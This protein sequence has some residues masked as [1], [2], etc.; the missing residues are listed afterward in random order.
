MA[1]EEQKRQLA[2]KQEKEQKAHLEEVARQQELKRQ[3]AEK[4]EKERQ[5]HLEEVARQQEAQ[6][7]RSS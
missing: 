2:E 1:T 7:R 6:R 5:A 4:Q 3:L